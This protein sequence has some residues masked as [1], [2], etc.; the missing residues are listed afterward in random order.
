MQRGWG[1]SSHNISY[2]PQVKY[3]STIDILQSLYEK[4]LLN[5]KFYYYTT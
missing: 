2:S 1:A 4:Y 3:A 5:M